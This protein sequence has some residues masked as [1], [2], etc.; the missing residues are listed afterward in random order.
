MSIAGS[1][2]AL[3]FKQIRATFSGAKPE[4]RA[5]GAKIKKGSGKLENVTFEKY[6]KYMCYGNTNAIELKF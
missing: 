4:K 1:R 6:S 3:Q 5:A 2:L